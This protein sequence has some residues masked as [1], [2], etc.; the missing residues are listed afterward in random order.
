[1][2]IILASKSKRRKELLGKINIK[3][4]VIDSKFN[5]SKIKSFDIAPNKLCQSLAFEKANKVSIKHKNDLIIGAD[6]IVYKDGRILGKPKTKVEAF[7]HLSLLSGTTHEVYTAVHILNKNKNI[8][9][10]LID[11]TKVTFYKLNK[12][13]KNYYIN[14]CNP[15]DKAGSYGIQGWSAI[16]VK[17]IQGCF[18]NVVGFPL[19]KFYKL[20]KN[21]LLKIKD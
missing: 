5:E 17:N 14:N 3:F 16:F 6:T 9:K 18:Y 19:P 13:E 1:M 4:K 21:F 11:K 8:N 20:F 12:D 15:F 7:S 2:N 10:R